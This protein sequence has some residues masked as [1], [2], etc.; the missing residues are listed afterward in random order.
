MIILKYFE[1]FKGDVLLFHY[2]SIENATS[3]L[4]QKNFKPRKYSILNKYLNDSDYG[5]ISF[6]TNDEYHEEPT[7]ILTEVRF[8]FN[9]KELENKYGLVEFDANVQS[10]ELYKNKYG[11]VDDL[12]IAN[13]D[14]FG[15]EEEYRIY[16]K[17]VPISYIKEIQFEDDIENE[18]DAKKL[19]MMCD[20]LNIKY[21]KFD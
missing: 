20:E 15:N 2:T 12:D 9:M 16:D 1:N 19:M 18:K 8:L 17:I 3:I 4:F 14:Y 10:E 6:T 7:E 5:Y 21:T 13:I 11:D